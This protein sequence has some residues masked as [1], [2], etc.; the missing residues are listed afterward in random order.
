MKRFIIE[1][2]LPG[3]AKLSGEELQT[4][5]QKSCEVIT[6]LDKQ[7]VWEHSYVADNKLYCVHMAPDQETV[8][9]HS[10]R[11][12]FPITSVH[13]VKTIIG[14]ATTTPKL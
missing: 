5:A 2:D 13:E 3:A 12:G 7:Y 1:R 4:I 10:R 11:G 9:E 14:P 6:H 8:I